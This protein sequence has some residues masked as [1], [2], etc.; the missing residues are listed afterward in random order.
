MPCCRG[1]LCELS[2]YSFSPQNYPRLEKYISI[3]P[4]EVRNTEEVATPVHCGPS[5]SVTDGKREKLREWVRTQ[6]CTGE[7]SGEPETLEHR[8]SVPRKSISEQWDG[9]VDNMAIGAGADREVK[10]RQTMDAPD[11]FFEDD[12]GNEDEL[13]AGEPTYTLSVKPPTKGRLDKSI[14][15][16]DKHL[17]LAEN[18]PWKGK[19]KKLEKPHSPTIQDSRFSDERE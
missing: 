3:F 19:R 14:N 12:M 7:M 9:S 15:L 17:K 2:F 11:D 4:P 8:Q 16:P 1:P 6:M 10:A 18:R 13:D 5:S